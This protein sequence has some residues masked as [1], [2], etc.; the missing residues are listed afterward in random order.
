MATSMPWT[1][2]TGPVGVLK[3]LASPCSWMLSP[4][5][6]GANLTGPGSQACREDELAGCLERGGD[7]AEHDRVLSEL[8][9]L[10]A[11]LEWGELAQALFQS[12]TQ[13]V[14]AAADAP[15][16]HDEL[17]VDQRAD[18]REQQGDAVGLDCDGLERLRVVAAGRIEDV[19]RSAG[20][21]HAEL[22]R[23]GH[24]AAGRGRLLEAPALG[25]CVAV[26][27]GPRDVADLAGSATAAAPELAVDDDARP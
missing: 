14:R 5:A 4:A 7:R 1:A 23:E 18:G 17:G 20:A 2:W 15:A 13:Q 11:R 24:D 21:L 26:G 9:F 25:R 19:L 6:I 8:A 12:W 16:E 27:A 10:D 22:L 3:D